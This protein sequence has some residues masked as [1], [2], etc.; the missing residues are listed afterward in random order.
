MLVEIE[1]LS[2]C[3]KAYIFFGMLVNFASLIAASWVLFGTYVMGTIN[4]VYP[5]VALFLQTLLIVASSF[6]CRFGPKDD[7]Y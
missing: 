3:L 2:V 1:D 5:G 7:G 6:L 4:P